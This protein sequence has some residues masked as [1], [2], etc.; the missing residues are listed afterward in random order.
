MQP[1]NNTI[2]KKTFINFLLL[3]LLCVAIITTT[4]FFSFQ[5]PLKQ[6]NQLLKDS[7]SYIKDK[8][9]SRAFMSEMS[10]IAGML[11]TI[12][13]KAGKPELL[14]GNITEGIKKLNAKIAEESVNDKEFYNSMVF[15]L[16][17][18][19]SAKKQLRDNTGKDLNADALRQE[20]ESLR[21]SL[22]AAKIENLN[23]KQQVFLLQ[24]QKQ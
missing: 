2:R 22:D 16:S 5:A 3:F 10:N 24:Q 4:I 17:D 23:L 19:Q 6:N 7:R 1:K 14:D 21:S 11:D 9:F 13:T 12:N 20:V 8:E 18:I 15:L